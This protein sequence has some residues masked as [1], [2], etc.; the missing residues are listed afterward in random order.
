MVKVVLFTR[1][2]TYEGRINLVTPLGEKLR[3]LDALN[4]PSRLRSSDGQTGQALRLLEATRTRGVRPVPLDLGDI[5]IRPDRIIAAY[6][7][8]PLTTRGAKSD[9]ERERHARIR[10]SMVVLLDNGWRLECQTGDRAGLLC[11]ASAQRPFVACTDVR[12]I[13]PHHDAESVL[14]FIAIN[15]A[16][17]EACASRQ[18]PEPGAE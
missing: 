5:S 10:R 8:E 9:Y 6:D 16:W 2:S 7:V 14:P 12:L 3:L 13:D 18:G 1:W 11:G 17:V 4:G 15:S